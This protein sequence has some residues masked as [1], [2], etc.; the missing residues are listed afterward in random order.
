MIHDVAYTYGYVC[1]RRN[2]RAEITV[3]SDLALIV[4]NIVVK[5][6]HVICSIL[7]RFDLRISAPFHK[8]HSL[9]DPHLLLSIVVLFIHAFALMIELLIDLVVSADHALIV[10]LA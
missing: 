9:K 3:F 7:L 2:V 8:H 4:E 5:H 10:R 1:L 6:L